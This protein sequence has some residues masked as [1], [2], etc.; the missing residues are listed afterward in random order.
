MVKYWWLNALIISATVV[1]WLSLLGGVAGAFAIAS[2]IDSNS[3]SITDLSND[4]VTAPTS[5]PQNDVSLYDHVP[6]DGPRSEQDYDLFRDDNNAVCIGKQFYYNE[7]KA[8]WLCP[9]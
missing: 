6:P 3:P 5:M 7:D 1:I 9:S 8:A 4:M 2:A